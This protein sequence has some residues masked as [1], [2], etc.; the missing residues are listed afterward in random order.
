MLYQS[1]SMPPGYHIDKE[2][3]GSIFIQDL[4]GTAPTAPR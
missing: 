3:G 1:S 4:R 2:D